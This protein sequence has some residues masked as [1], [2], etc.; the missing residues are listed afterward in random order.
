[1]RNRSESSQV[2]WAGFEPE[3][4]AVTQRVE[5]CYCAP[6][7]AG[8]SGGFR[9]EM[10]HEM[11]DAERRDKASVRTGEDTGSRQDP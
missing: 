8:G 2:A 10:R 1:M 7:R 9:K 6:A 4:I 3:R 5:G 11:K